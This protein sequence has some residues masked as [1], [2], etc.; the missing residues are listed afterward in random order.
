[1]QLRP[2]EAK[3]MKLFAAGK[4]SEEICNELG[5]KTSTMKTVLHQIRKRN[6]VTTNQ[7][8]AMF[9]KQQGGLSA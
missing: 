1:M 7:L 8:I 6:N 3:L 9:T 5:I 2:S 4:S